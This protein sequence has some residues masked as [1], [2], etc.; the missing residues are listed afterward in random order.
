MSNLAG[1]SY[2]LKSTSIKAYGKF[3]LKYALTMK[4]PIEGL[5]RH[6]SG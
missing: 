4:Q 5:C 3:E 2:H 1:S 6:A